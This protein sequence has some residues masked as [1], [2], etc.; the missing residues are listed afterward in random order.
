MHFDDGRVITPSRTNLFWDS[1]F[2]FY[3]ARGSE[4][5]RSAVIV[6]ESQNHN[7]ETDYLFREP[8]LHRHPRT[9]TLRLSDESLTE[10]VP[11]RGPVSSAYTVLILLRLASLL[12]IKLLLLHPAYR[13]KKSYIT[14]LIV[15]AIT[16]GLI[17][18]IAPSFSATLMHTLGIA[19]IFFSLIVLV[20][21]AIVFSFLL[22]EHDGSD[23]IRY[24]FK[25]N[26]ATFA[27]SLIWLFILYNMYANGSWSH[28]FHWTPFALMW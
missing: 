4:T 10:E 3:N 15:G 1:F 9:H 7:F 2:V 5:V 6:V 28:I 25:S 14:V 12:G 17:F 8:P 24:T 16:Q 19:L 18:F 22:Q 20:V 23:A 13:E 27:L 26:L 21:E 11:Q